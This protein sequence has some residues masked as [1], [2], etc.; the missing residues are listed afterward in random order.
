MFA[1]AQARLAAAVRAWD[2]T[3]VEPVGQGEIALVRGARRAG[4]AVVV[5]VNPRGH[6]E[7]RQLAAE[8]AALAHWAATGAAVALLDRRDD[9]LTLLLERLGA[10]LAA[11]GAGYEAQ[12]DVLGALARRLH[13]AGRPPDGALR[14]AEYVP[15]WPGRDAELDALLVP[16]PGDVL[17]HLDLHHY[18]AL[19]HDGGWRIIDPKGALGDRHADVW[20]LLNPGAPVAPDAATAR[21]WVARYARAAGLD[22]ERTVAWTRARARGD[23]VGTVSDPAWSQRLL[24]IAAL[25]SS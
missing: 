6:R 8:G 1:D 11:A 12:L 15:E 19:R 20:A 10:P 5:K 14:I 25:L 18:N 21:A 17:V 22:V 7:E 9:G 13:A 3:D 2:L 24:R 16:A 23:A 4:R